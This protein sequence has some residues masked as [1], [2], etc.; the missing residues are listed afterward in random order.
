MII[1]ALGIYTRV[2]RR[3]HELNVHELFNIAKKLKHR[4]NIKCQ[5][6]VQ[7][8]KIKIKA[9]NRKSLI[10]MRG[11]MSCTTIIKFSMWHTCAAQLRGMQFAWVTQPFEKLRKS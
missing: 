2:S 5:L 10:G 7:Q 4:I 9:T 11:Y 6:L 8:R 3:L 1:R